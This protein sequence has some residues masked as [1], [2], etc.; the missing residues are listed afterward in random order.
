MMQLL[1]SRDSIAYC[2]DNGPEIFLIQF[3]IQMYIQSTMILF[4]IIFGGLK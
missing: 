1:P 3:V 4:A 2:K